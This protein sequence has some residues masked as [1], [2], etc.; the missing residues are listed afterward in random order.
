MVVIALLLFSESSLAMAK[1]LRVGMSVDFAPYFYLNE[2]EQPSGLIVDYWR[3]WSKKTGIEVQFIPLLWA[4]IPQQIDA[5]TIDIPIAM[6]KTSNREKYLNFGQVLL[7]TDN[8]FFTLGSQQKYSRG[9]EDL[10]NKLIGVIDGSYHQHYLKNNYPLIRLKRY[11]NAQDLASAVEKL[12]ILAFF[13]ETQSTIVRLR[14]HYKSN[15]LSKLE[16]AAIKRDFYVAIPKHSKLS[17][18][19]TLGLKK[20]TK[21]ELLGITQRWLVN[22]S[23]HRQSVPSQVVITK[24]GSSVDVS[25]ARSAIDWSVKQRNASVNIALFNELAPYVIKNNTARGIVIDLIESAL[26]LSNITNSKTL[27]HSTRGIDHIFEEEP[28]L[29]IAVSTLIRDDLYY[30]DNLFR[31]E[32]IVI[33]RKKDNLFISELSDLSN[34][35]VMA[36]PGAHQKLGQPYQQIFSPKV[37]PATYIEAKNIAQIEAFFLG[38]TDIII[39]DKKVFIWL[40]KQQGYQDISQFKFDYLFPASSAIKLAFKDPTLRDLFNKNLATLKRSG[41]YENIIYDYLLGRAEAKRQ[42]SLFSASLFSQPLFENDLPTLLS[43]MTKLRS[44]KY[45]SDIKITDAWG[46]DILRNDYNKEFVGYIQPSYYVQANRHIRVGNVT[47]EYNNRMITDTIN[48]TDLIPDKSMLSPSY[49]A[50]YIDDIYRQFNVIEHQLSLTRKEQRFIDSHPIIRY[51]ETPWQPISIID[52]NHFSGV[53]A[54]YLQLITKISGLKFRFQP[55]KDWQEVQHKLTQHKIDIIPSVS[56]Y[57]NEALISAP[58]TEFNFVIVTKKDQTY[59]S[60]L[61]EFSGKTLA[62]P[63]GYIS[64]QRVKENHPEIEVIATE[65]PHQALALVRAG[66]ADGFVG[67]LAIAVSKLKSE[68]QDLKISGTIEHKYIHHM[69]INKN[70]PLLH[71]IINKAIRAITPQQRQQI[72]NRWITVDLDKRTDYILVYQTIGLF[73]LILLLIL[74]FVKSV[75][76]ANRQVKTANDQLECSIT[77]LTTTELTLN[78]TIKNLRATQQQLIAAEKMASLGAL[79]AGISHEI[80]TP[81]GIGLTGISHFQ[82]LTNELKVKYQQQRISKS[83]FEHYISNSTEVAHLVRNNLEKT[84]DLIHSFKQLS[85]DQMNDK[86]RKFN[87]RNYIQET[88]ISI[89]S[90]IKNPN[91]SINLQCHDDIII[92]SYPGALSQVLTNLILNCTNHAFDH[93][94]QGLI[95]INVKLSHDLVYLVISDNGKGIDPTH[96][97]QIFEPFFTT[98]RK[99]GGSGLGLNIVYN[100]VTSQLNGSITCQSKPDKGT[101]FT[102]KFTPQQ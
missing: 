26:S 59:I 7:T 1:P 37:R 55:S 63:T 91:L 93:Q 46:D 95:K 79:V 89:K 43:Y 21:Q 3:L 65:T 57:S 28:E 88:L 18:V 5:G 47:I 77:T 23:I 87:L 15:R 64:Y 72:Y 9:I 84:A 102:I 61:S 16:L 76:R 53:A 13:N 85:V 40:A 92:N 99:N 6:Y 56:Q 62:L 82:M 83:D 34:K 41:G 98:N 90:V 30:S 54:D 78:E 31:F 14:K 33:S 44:L 12:E 94:Q 49:N 50:S 100:I 75:L 17:D 68:F 101:V 32:N 51:S 70:L 67:H 86:R 42:F 71:S 24:K 80:N 81:V 20:I 73:S 4:D 10:N 60:E 45:I 96:L 97:R 66:K 38:Q 69:A 39:L 8:D 2:S 27:H 74:F 58:Y 52:N 48:K 36:F 29:D 22:L 11:K 35:R 19:I 25:A